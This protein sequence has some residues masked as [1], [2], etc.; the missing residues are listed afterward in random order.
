[1]QQMDTTEAAGVSVDKT[2]RYMVT[3][4]DG[5]QIPMIP[6]PQDVSDL[7]NV[8]GTDSVVKVG[9]KG[10]VLMSY[11]STQR[12]GA[13]ANEEVYVYFVVIFDPFIDPSLQDFCDASGCNWDSMNLQ[14]GV[15]FDDNGRAKQQITVVYSQGKVQKAYPTVLAPDTFIKEAKKFAGVEDIVYNTD[16]SFTLTYQGQTLYLYPT[17]QVIAKKLEQYETVKPSLVQRDDGM[18]EYSVQT[19]ELLLTSVV[20]ISE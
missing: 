20:S 6:A 7:V 13:R 8:L 14:P 17:T 12:R 10:D 11:T 1:M 15:N 5:W 19:G 2:G 18:L 16:G 3:T 9:K 4:E